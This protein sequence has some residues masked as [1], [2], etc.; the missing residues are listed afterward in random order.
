LEDLRK[1]IDALERADPVR[2]WDAILD[3]KKKLDELLYQEE[4]MWLQRS[5]VNWLKEGD[6][7]TKYSHQRARW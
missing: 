1:E 3:S 6:R 5:R 7:N 4:M 2:N